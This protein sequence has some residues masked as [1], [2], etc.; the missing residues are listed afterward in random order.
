[1]KSTDYEVHN[2]EQSQ[3]AESSTSVCVCLRGCVSIHAH[4]TVSLLP[5]LTCGMPC[6]HI[7][8]RTWTIDISSKHW[9]DTC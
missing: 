4:T 7:C 2:V 5:D 9:R 3:T 1:V 8:G 6:H